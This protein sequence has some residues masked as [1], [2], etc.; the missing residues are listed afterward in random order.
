MSSSIQSKRQ[1]IRS[2]IIFLALVASILL[3]LLP[4]RALPTWGQTASQNKPTE[5]DTYKVRRVE[6]VGNEHTKDHLIAR[7][8]AFSIGSPFSERDI[9]RTIKNLNRWGRLQQIKREDIIVT[10]SI[11]DPETTS[12]HCFADVLVRVK[13]KAN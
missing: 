4:S 13:E 6:V 5:C 11:S 9:E 2:R 1:L 8:I 12:W 7:R 10:F 3:M